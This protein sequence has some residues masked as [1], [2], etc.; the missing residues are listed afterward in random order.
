MT[1]KLINDL[2]A[3]NRLW[4]G[5]AQP[6]LTSSQ[7]PQGCLED[8]Q[9]R[10]KYNDQFYNFNSGLLG[11]QEFKYHSLNAGRQ[12]KLVD[13]LDVYS[14]MMPSYE[15][16]MYHDGPSYE[17]A[18]H[19]TKESDSSSLLDK[20]I[21]IAKQSFSKFITDN[22]ND[23]RKADKI[24]AINEHK[25]TDDQR[26]TLKKFTESVGAYSKKLREQLAN[27][28][29]GEDEFEKLFKTEDDRK[30]YWNK[31][32]NELNKIL[33]EHNLHNLA[34]GAPMFGGEADDLLQALN[35]EK[36]RLYRTNQMYGGMKY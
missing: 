29:G 23:A 5:I 17:S 20:M 22:I 4:S 14:Q 10:F 36:E 18:S 19:F 35:A 13:Q 27:K 34:G 15:R 28:V 33:S 1:D 25:L 16:T 21:I 26:F 9:S 12:G 2:F 31:L 11:N 7:N 6:S 24:T 32:F 8:A 3:R 30:I